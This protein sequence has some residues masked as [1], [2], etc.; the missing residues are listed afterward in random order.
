VPDFDGLLV[1]SLEQAVAAPYCTRRLCDAGARVIKLERSTGDFARGY[2]D[3]VRDMSSY[4]VWLNHG[5]ESICFDLKL[6]ADIDLLWRMLERADVFVQNLVPGATER[7]GIGSADLR[8]R[9][10]RLI[11]CDISGYG[12]AG[13]Y[14]DMKAYDLLV[15]AESG[16]AFISGSP[17]SAGRVGVSV[18]DIACG[19]TAYEGILRALFA[20]ERSGHGRAVEASLFH[21]VADWMNVPYLQYRY[22][23][24]APERSGLHHPTIA[25]YGC[26][27]CSDGDVILAVQNEREWLQFCTTLLGD[28]AVADDARFG[29]NVNRVKN[30]VELDALIG[31]VLR[32]LTREQATVRLTAASIAF[33]N[34]STIEDLAHHPQ[35]R[36]AHVGTP[37]GGVDIIEPP[38]AG[39]GIRA[40]FGAV[41]AAGQHDRAVR[42]EFERTTSPEDGRPAPE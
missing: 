14:R 40:T 38:E 41:P 10:P 24:A 35:A 1:V 29:T 13:P 25:P 21:S 26:Y 11:T 20:R 18:C 17:E 12:S 30:R 27:A 6:D 9:F 31:Q 23:G 7:A 16:L 33:G 28:A 19:M 42:L 34:L 2:D 22:G 8:A 37:S 36:F 32:G 3:A 5:K 4:F 39:E 15:Q